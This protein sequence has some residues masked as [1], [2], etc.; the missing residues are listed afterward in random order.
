MSSSYFGIAQSRQHT[1]KEIEQEREGDRRTGVLGRSD[2]GQHK[3]AGTDHTPDSYAYQVDP[4]QRSLQPLHQFDWP[5][6]TSI[7]TKLQSG[8]AFIQCT[9]IECSAMRLAFDIAQ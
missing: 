5:T 4:C 2:S 8:A 6:S 7:F 1:S 9:S 3:D